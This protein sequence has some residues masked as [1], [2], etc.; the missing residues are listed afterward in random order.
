MVVCDGALAAAVLTV[1]RGSWEN[2]PDC[3]YIIEVFTTPGQRRRGLARATMQATMATLHAAGE[4][5]VA[6][7]VASENG[8]ALALYRA[9]GFAEADGA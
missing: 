4:R 7:T 5:Q 1:R 9:L 2:A 6:L 3:P 8:P